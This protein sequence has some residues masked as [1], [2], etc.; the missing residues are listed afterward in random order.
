MK[1]FDTVILIRKLYA[2]SWMR[3]LAR[4]GEGRVCQA[5]ATTVVFRTCFHEPRIR[6]ERDTDEL[7]PAFG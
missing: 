3:G 5:S 4:C 2:C 7:A 6:E 1:I